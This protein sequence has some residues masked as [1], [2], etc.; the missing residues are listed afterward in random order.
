MDWIEMLVLAT[1]RERIFEQTFTPL[2]FFIGI[3]IL[4]SVSRAVLPKKYT[5]WIAVMAA[6]GFLIF[7]VDRSRGVNFYSDLVNFQCIICGVCGLGLSFYAFRLEN[8]KSYRGNLSSRFSFMAFIGAIL[9]IT[10][11]MRIVSLFR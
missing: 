8:L 10:T 4:L 6:V 1:V 11:S 7:P 2:L 9:F 3:W 5:I